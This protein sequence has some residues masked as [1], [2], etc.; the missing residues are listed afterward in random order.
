MDESFWD[1]LL[2]LL[3][4]HKISQADISKELNLSP[5]YLSASISR[6]AS[7]RA[8]FAVKVAD[9]FK[10]SLK[11]LITGKDDEAIDVKYAVAI[12][13]KRIMEIAYLLTKCQE[14]FVTAIENLVIYAASNQKTFAK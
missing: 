2:G 13:N 5:S 14:D 11:W 4:V 6:G 12:K 7:P 10:V 8:D 9:Y 3:S 1:R